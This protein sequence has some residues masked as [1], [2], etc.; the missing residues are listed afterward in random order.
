MSG[1]FV[2]TIAS[3]LHTVFVFQVWT[4]FSR[5]ARTNTAANLFRSLDGIRLILSYGMRDVCEQQVASSEHTYLR[6]LCHSFRSGKSADARY[7][8]KLGLGRFSK[9]S[10]YLN[11]LH[12]Y[13][14]KKWCNSSDYSQNS[15]NFPSEKRYETLGMEVVKG[16]WVQICTGKWCNGSFNPRKSSGF[17]SLTTTDLFSR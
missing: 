9:G 8:F 16:L 3:I 15:A 14:W 1:F 12:N 4:W 10:S 11:P 17:K 13:F 7:R 6:I 5:Y 2:K